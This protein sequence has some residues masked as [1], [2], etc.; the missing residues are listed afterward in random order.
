MGGRRHCCGQYDMQENLL[1]AH[2]DSRVQFSSVTHAATL[3]ALRSYFRKHRNLAL[4]R[5]VMMW[6][7]FCLYIVVAVGVL[8]KGKPKHS[9][10]L[11]FWLAQFW[12]AATYI[13][14]FGVT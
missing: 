4:I 6:I 10:K 12:H 13:D 11:P 14:V 5:V 7:T 3:V 9:A 8:K 2:A 1:I